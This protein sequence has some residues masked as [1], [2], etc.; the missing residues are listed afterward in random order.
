M[1]E[2]AETKKKKFVDIPF[3]FFFLLNNRNFIENHNI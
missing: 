3:F 2:R 1:R